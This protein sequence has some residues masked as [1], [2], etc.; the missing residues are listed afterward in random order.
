MELFSKFKKVLRREFIATLNFQKFRVVL[1]PLRR[2]ILNFEKVA[3]YH[4]DYN[5]IIK[6]EGHRARF[7]VISA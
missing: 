6:N 1:N 3:S 5:L 4:A 2:L 7:R